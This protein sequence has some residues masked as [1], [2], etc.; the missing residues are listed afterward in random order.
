MVVLLAESICNLISNF[1]GASWD[2]FDLEYWHLI[3]FL[4]YMN[5]SGLMLPFFQGSKQTHFFKTRILGS[6]WLVVGENTT[7]VEKL[8]KLYQ[9]YL[10]RLDCCCATAAAV[11]HSAPPRRRRAAA[12]PPL[13]AA[14]SGSTAGHFFHVLENYPYVTESRG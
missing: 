12:A 14:A 8:Y 11:A 5:F 7:N 1:S 13:P 2:S 3:F 10:A 9:L 6:D 4:I